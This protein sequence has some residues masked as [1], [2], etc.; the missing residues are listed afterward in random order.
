MQL[1]GV[2]FDTLAMLDNP[3]GITSTPGRLATLDMDMDMGTYAM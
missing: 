3:D 2:I 1:L